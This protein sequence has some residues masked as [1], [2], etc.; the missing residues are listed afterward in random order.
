MWG[1]GGG[2]GKATEQTDLEMIRGGG[3][4]LLK[5]L[6]LVPALPS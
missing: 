3:E 6:V 1:R 5:Q 4:S 2:G